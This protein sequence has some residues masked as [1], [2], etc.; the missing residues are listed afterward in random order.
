MENVIEQVKPEVQET[1][2]EEQNKVQEALHRVMLAA[3]GTVGLVQDEVEH[4]VNKAVERGQIAE[5]DARQTVNQATERRKG[6]TKE[7]D[8]RMEDMLS[9]LNIPSKNDIDLLNEKIAEL[10]QKVEALK[11]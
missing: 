1:V 4:F 5:K 10:S 7:V 11:N 9:K 3:V 2:T 6:A 8:K